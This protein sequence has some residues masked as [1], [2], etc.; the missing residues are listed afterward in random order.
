MQKLANDRYVLFSD[1]CVSSSRN[2]D[3]DTDDFTSAE[4]GDAV[5]VIALDNIIYP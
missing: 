4:W 5:A 2:S 1:F 3:D